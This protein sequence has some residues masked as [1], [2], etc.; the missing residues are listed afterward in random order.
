MRD[1]QINP[2]PDDR[3]FGKTFQAPKPREAFQQK[4]ANMMHRDAPIN[5]GSLM[6]RYGRRWHA[7]NSAPGMRKTINELPIL[8]ESAKKMLAPRPLWRADRR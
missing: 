8:I 5:S 1:W 7:I 4:V 2:V 6:S 3:E